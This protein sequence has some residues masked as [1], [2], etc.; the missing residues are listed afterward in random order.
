M[1]RL[2]FVCGLVFIVAACG[3][4]DS[5]E[6]GSDLATVSSPDG[7][8][9][10]TIA[11]GSL[12]DGVTVDDL[13]IDWAEGLSDE[14]GAPGVGVR[15]SPDGLVL[16]E[17]ATL[18]LEL[19][20]SMA[21]HLVVA[22]VTSNGF[23]LIGGEIEPV[24]GTRFLT[25]KVQHFSSIFVHNLPGFT[26]LIAEANPNIV[27]VGLTQVVTS[28]V[29]IE[30]VPLSLWIPTAVDGKKS[31][32]FTFD[33]IRL[34]TEAFVHSGVVVWND[35]KDDSKSWDP[36]VAAAKDTTDDGVVFFAGSS[37]CKIVNSIDPW[38]MNTVALTMNVK[39]VGAVI[40]RTFIKFGRSVGQAFDEGSSGEKDDNDETIP[41]SAVVGDTVEG[42][43]MVTTTVESECVA[44]IAETTTTP[45]ATTTTAGE[46]SQGPPGQD[47]R[48]HVAGITTYA[49]VNNT[50]GLNVTFAGPWVNQTDPT[51]VEPPFDLFSFFIWF[52]ILQG[53]L[54]AVAGWEI[55]NGTVTLPGTGPMFLRQDGSMDIDTG[56]PVGP[57]VVIHIEGRNGSWG[58]E[59]GS[60][61]FDMFV[62]SVNPSDP[63]VPEEPRA[64]EYDLLTGE[65]LPPLP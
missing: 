21:D 65:P 6:D 25:T 47:A 27:A 26:P 1:K 15:L 55:H 17:E 50:I 28:E 62:E 58:T 5:G 2:T 38:I 51:I 24:D 60:P 37:A 48:A 52:N 33:G 44:S 3:G 8:A 4:G 53:N 34:S 49:T 43:F 54:S 45:P 35:K 32:M 40:D 36:E 22:H 61:I 12:P 59:A 23:T 7:K 20:N 42:K 14:P 18:R 30:P 13:Q 29:R 56:F 41:F 57:V 46:M 9:E 39:A 63:L 16:N 19:P 64:Q 11:A 10:L 31:Q